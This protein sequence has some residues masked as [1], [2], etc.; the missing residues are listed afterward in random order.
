V[1]EE[2]GITGGTLRD[3]QHTNVYEIYPPGATAMR[4]A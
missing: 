4:R 3:W 1:A 2:T